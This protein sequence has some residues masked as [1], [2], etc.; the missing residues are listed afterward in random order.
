[1]TESLWLVEADMAELIEDG[2]GAAWVN[3][4]ASSGREHPL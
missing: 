1:M 3:T 2:L 4:F